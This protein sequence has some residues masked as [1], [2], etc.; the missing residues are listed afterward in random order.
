MDRAEWE[1]FLG[2]L[3]PW[4]REVGE[5]IWSFAPKRPARG[6]ETLKLQGTALV[7]GSKKG[8]F[9]ALYLQTLQDLETIAKL[10]IK[11]ILSGNQGWPKAL[12]MVESPP[13]L[14]Y[15]RGQLPQGEGVGI[16]GPRRA[17]A[18][19][20]D[21]AK[22]L[23][24]VYVAQGAWIISGGAAGVD[25]AAHEGALEAGGNTVVVM[26]TG[27]SHVY[28]RGHYRLFERAALHGALLSEYPPSFPGRAWAFPRRNRLVA[29]LCTKMVVVEP[30]R[31]SGSLITSRFALK[32]GKNVH[33]VPGPEGG[34]ELISM[35]DVHPLLEDCDR[36]NIRKHALKRAREE[37]IRSQT[38]ISL[39][40]ASM[41]S[42][43]LGRDLCQL[44]I[45]GP[46]R[47]E[48]L[49]SGLDATPGMVCGRLMELELERVIVEVEPSLYQLYGPMRA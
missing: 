13:K 19:A 33:T 37:T 35:H 20:L 44:M 14:I 38:T 11:V 24:G 40:G 43:E 41:P 9:K 2:S 30:R 26:G 42:D 5:Q 16:V 36:R 4:E 25:R 29:S 45:G 48:A 23:A 28:P 12:N 18:W 46:I 6:P 39:K 17:S 32:Y 47:L 49:V 10:N 31:G 15:L 27:H 22:E 1:S 7:S 8:G 3:A 21:Q 34:Q